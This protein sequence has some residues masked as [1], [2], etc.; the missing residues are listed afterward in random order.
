MFCPKDFSPA[1]PP[2]FSVCRPS[3]D[4]AISVANRQQP[5][6]QQKAWTGKNPITNRPV[7]PPQPNGPLTQANKLPP[8]QQ[9]HLQ[10][11]LNALR[12]VSFG[13][14]SWPVISCFLVRCMFSIVQ[15][16]GEFKRETV[17][18]SWADPSGLAKTCQSFWEVGCD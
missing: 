4:Q 17:E 8:Q 7:N 5:P 12:E 6:V 11:V 15:H 3:T 1:L 18:N 16:R 14:I 10:V 9:Q 13:P 2:T